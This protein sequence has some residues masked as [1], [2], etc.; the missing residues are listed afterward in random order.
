MYFVCVTVENERSTA[1][2]PLVFGLSRNM[3]TSLFLIWRGLIRYTS[4]WDL[5]TRQRMVSL[6]SSSSKG[7]GDGI[8]RAGG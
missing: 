5:W 8:W 2:L 1:S 3:F 7:N 4:T 6:Q